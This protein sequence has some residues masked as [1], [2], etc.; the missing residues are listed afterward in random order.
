MCTG[1][2]TTNPQNSNAEHTWFACMCAT[3]TSQHQHA[4]SNMQ[5][6]K[7]RLIPGHN[8][9]WLIMHDSTQDAAGWFPATP[10]MLFTPKHS[11]LGYINNESHAMLG[12]M[13]HDAAHY[14]QYLLASAGSRCR[15]GGNSR[16]IVGDRVRTTGGPG[17]AVATDGCAARVGNGRAR[18]CVC[19]IGLGVGLSRASASSCTS[20]VLGHGQAAR[21]CLDCGGPRV[22]NSSTSAGLGCRRTGALSSACADGDSLVVGGSSTHARLGVSVGVGQCWPS[23]ALCNGLSLCLGC[24]ALLAWATVP[25]LG[26]VLAPLALVPA[27]LGAHPLAVVPAA[28][29]VPLLLQLPAG[30]SKGACRGLVGR[31][32]GRTRAS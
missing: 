8:I 13:H 11:P 23:A 19:C 10:S 18:A 4:L 1:S 14:R 3:T 24:R 26:P 27:A 25:L 20:K 22:G 30:P 29:L 12:C 31:D 17:G 9:I 6:H 28:P 2:P 5:Q 16:A 7:P 32:E 21:A 15:R